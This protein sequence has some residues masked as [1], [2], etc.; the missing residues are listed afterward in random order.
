[1]LKLFFENAQGVDQKSSSSNKFSKNQYTVEYQFSKP[2]G[3]IRLGRDRA[4]GKYNQIERR[5]DTV[6]KKGSEIVAMIDAKYMKSDHKTDKKSDNIK[7]MPDTKI[8]NQ[9]IIAM[10]YGASTTDLGIVLFADDRKQDDVVIEKIQKHKE[11]HFLNM[12]PENKRLM[13]DAF[14][15]I[16]NIVGIKV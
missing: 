2:I 10:D 4:G 6:I 9:M 1:M 11:I 13:D 15:K 12:H 7:G 14:V 5:P 16:K 8:V 3:W